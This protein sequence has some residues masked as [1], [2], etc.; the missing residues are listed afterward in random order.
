MR[1]QVTG[2]VGSVRP[3]AVRAADRAVQLGVGAARRS[4]VALAVHELLANALEHGHGGDPALP[5]DLRVRRGHGDT[6]RIE[7][8]DRA[9]DGLW[10][11]PDG[12]RHRC[13]PLA[14]RGHGWQLVT[15]VADALRV[16]GAVGA[17]VVRVDLV[18]DDPRQIPAASTEGADCGVRRG[19]PVGW[20]AL[21]GG[22][23]R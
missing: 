3:A 20:P 23:P 19:R 8:T 16:E 17:T 10:Q 7:V 18:V 4:E 5:I 12:D 22:L 14:C 21:S 15:A 9:V 2:G 13:E 1:W 11:G 6:I